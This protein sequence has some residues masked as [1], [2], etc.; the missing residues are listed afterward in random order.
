MNGAS[1]VPH[2]HHQRRHSWPGQRLT[3]GASSVKRK[4]PDWKSFMFQESIAVAV[5][6]V[7]V[8]VLSIV[9]DGLLQRAATVRWTKTEEADAD[10][11]SNGGFSYFVALIAWLWLRLLPSK[12]RK[13][14][15]TTSVGIGGGTP[16]FMLAHVVVLLKMEE[17]FGMFPNLGC[18]ICEWRLGRIRT[19]AM[20][21]A[22]LVHTIVPCLVWAG[23]A[24]VFS[25]ECSL[26]S[27]PLNSLRYSQDHDLGGLG[28]SSEVLVYFI[29]EVF[30]STMFPLVVMVLPQLLKLNELPEWL[31][32]FC[33]YPIYSMGVDAYG[34]GS[35]LCTG[36]VLAQS[37][38]FWKFD[39]RWRLCAQFMGSFLAG[40]IMA[41]A[42]P[43]D[44][45]V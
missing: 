30:V 2:P 16:G 45:P 12:L 5:W 39:S 43:D 18:R 19:R 8:I 10:D 36:A 28:S 27:S 29:K 15:A 38:F 23:L 35:N 42:F 44:P 4:F 17:Q 14:S 25:N 9:V 34:K 21:V 40:A 24:M 13:T 20:F 6:S 32:F 37:L 41:N 7:S 11:S 3:T 26:V 31:T 1:Q 33:V 22:L